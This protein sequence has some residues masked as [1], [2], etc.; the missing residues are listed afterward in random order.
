MARYVW[1][2]DLRTWVPYEEYWSNRVVHGRAFD[3]VP[4]IA[5]FVSPL[6]GKTVGSRSA[7]REHEKKFGVKQ[8]G[9]LTR[10]SD[11]DNKPVSLARLKERQRREI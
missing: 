9:E 3:I 10:A 1:D 6:D 8:C 4:D 5:E 7:L 11:F 2:D